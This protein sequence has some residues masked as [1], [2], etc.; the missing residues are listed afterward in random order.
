[1]MRGAAHDQPVAC[2]GR[3]HCHIRDAVPVIITLDIEV[4][5]MSHGL[6]PYGIVRAVE[7]IPGQASGIRGSGHRNIG[8]ALTAKVVMPIFGADL[9]ADLPGRMAGGGYLEIPKSDPKLA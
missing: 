2:R 3:K 5:S 8:K 9:A 1:M 6:G 7:N 4:I